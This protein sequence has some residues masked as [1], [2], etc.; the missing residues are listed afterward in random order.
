M[1]YALKAISWMNEILIKYTFMIFGD[2]QMKV[3]FSLVGFK[4]TF[5]CFSSKMKVQ[6]VDINNNLE[7]ICFPFGMQ[8]YNLSTHSYRH[9]HSQCL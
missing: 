1:R 7:F 4:N 6:F 9:L 2:F 5:S 8:S 3:R